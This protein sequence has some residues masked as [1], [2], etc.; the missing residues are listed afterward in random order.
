MERLVLL[1]WLLSMFLIPLCL[2]IGGLFIVYVATGKRL[3][4]QITTVALGAYLLLAGGSGAYAYTFVPADYTLFGKWTTHPTASPL[5]EIHAV[6]LQRVDIPGM[7][8]PDVAAATR[9]Q[10]RS[11]RRTFLMD[12][13]K[14]TFYG[15][16]VTLLA[17][18]WRRRKVDNHEALIIPGKALS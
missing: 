1:V 6:K 15:L 2:L 4:W 11:E 17:L 7:M 13:L 3:W 14:L 12:W 9:E 16:A 5:G 18:L 10:V 8:S